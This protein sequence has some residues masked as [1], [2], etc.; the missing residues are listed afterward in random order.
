MCYS[1]EKF[2]W[3]ESEYTS[4]CGN[5]AQRCDYA[6]KMEKNY[7]EHL[8][9]KDNRNNVIKTQRY[10]T[11]SKNVIILQDWRKNILG[12][13]NSPQIRL[14]NSVEEM[15]YNNRPTGDAW[16]PSDQVIMSIF[17]DE[18][19]IQKSDTYQ[20]R[21]NLVVIFLVHEH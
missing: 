7:A 16:I 12:K 2:K 11:E 19:V 17:L 5:R 9:I 20:V 15:W 21:I 6:A 14:L 3:Q 1:H 13:I 8:Q 18:S 10:S 4:L